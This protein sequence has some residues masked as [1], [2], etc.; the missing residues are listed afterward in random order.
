MI[1]NIILFTITV[2]LSIQGLNAQ[3]GLTI[4]WDVSLSMQN[5]DIEQDFL[6]LETY[7]SK[8]QNVS[9]RVLMFSNEVTKDDVFSV[10]NGDWAVLKNHLDASVYDGATSYKQIANIVDS[11][12]VLLF[13]DGFQNLEHDTAKFNANIKV[14]NSNALWKKESL[15]LLSLVNS[16]EY[17]NLSKVDDRKDRT[18]TPKA[19]GE[20]QRTK[21]IGIRLDEVTVEGK[22]KIAPVEETI[23][24]GYGKEDKNKVGYAVQS[25]GEDRISAITTDV[26]T[27]VQG[28][29]SGVHIGLNDDLS[30]AILRVKNSMLLNNYAMIVLDGVPLPRSN[31][32]KSGSI[33]DTSFINPENIADITVLKGLAATNRYGTL[34]SNGVILITSKTAQ[35]GTKSDEPQDLARLKNNIYEDKLIAQK[36]KLDTPYIKALKKAKSV[37]DAY[38]IYIK[39]RAKYQGSPEF[40]IDVY[41]FFKASDKLIAN[42]ILSNVLEVFSENTA[43]MRA[44]AFNHQK[45]N[46]HEAALH[47]FKVILQQ[48]PKSSQAYVDMAL[49]YRDMGNYQKSLDLFNGM[50]QGNYTDVDFSGLEKVIDAEIKNLY[51]LHKTKLNLKKTDPAF[52]KNVRYDA[53]IVV[54]WSDSKA[55]FVLQFVNPQ[56]RFFKWSHTYSENPKRLNQEKKLGFNTE[57]FQLIGAGK[58]DWLI[59]VK[60][61]G[62]GGVNNTEPLYIKTTIYYNYGSPAQRMEHHLVRLSETGSEV[63]LAKIII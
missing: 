54:D 36:I 17:I 49:L 26:S 1:K 6:F 30:Q 14:V 46:N 20:L 23:T 5:R 8:N 9:V 41:D 48:N 59:N 40:F 29:F 10:E 27:A 31:S 61:M 12:E 11:G 25:I 18:G 16:G 56:K 43:M 33:A 7:F 53:R 28:K 19:I 50:T 38:D 62:K 58:G 51:T 45:A 3:V 21:D 2:C 24:T 44:L 60:Y 39:E 52:L 4:C 55:E 47:V 35:G 32:T 22:E 57:E 34:G 63:A 42:R 37:G 13:T 15:L